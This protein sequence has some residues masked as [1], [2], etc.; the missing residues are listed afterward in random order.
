MGD[1]E[2]MNREK[3]L[4]LIRRHLSEALWLADGL[5]TTPGQLCLADTL[6]GALQDLEVLYPLA[7]ARAEKSRAA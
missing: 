6:R 1:G 3:H 2:T 5:P 7:E 4:L